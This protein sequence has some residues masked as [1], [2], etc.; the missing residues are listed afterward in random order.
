MVVIEATS[1]HI[2]MGNVGKPFSYVLIMPEKYYLA[3]RFDTVALLTG[4][5]L[6]TVDHSSLTHLMGV[7]ILSVFFIRRPVF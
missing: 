1:A 2:H 7:K 3:L 5:A 6:N 4:A